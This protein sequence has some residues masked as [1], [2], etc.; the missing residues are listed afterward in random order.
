MLTEAVQ[1]KQGKNTQTEK[2]SVE[3]DLG[4]DAY[5]PGTYIEDERQKI[6]IYKRIRELETID[7]LDE[8]QDDLLDRFGEYPSEVAHLLSV[9]E[10]KMNGDRSLIDRIKRQGDQVAFTL[11]KAGT[12]AYDMEQL[13]GAL[14]KT[15]LKSTLGVEKDQ[16]HIKLTIP[17]AMKTMVWLNEIQSFVGA[18]RKARFKK[19]ASAKKSE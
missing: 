9:G 11:S 13:F 10:L 3:I 12:K 1:R 16:M 8:L 19:K 2:T 4:L 7:N 17:K 18:L 15:K 5:L 14:S 6:E